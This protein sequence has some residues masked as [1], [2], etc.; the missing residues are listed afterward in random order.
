[1]LHA[2]LNY[3]WLKNADVTEIVSQL[4]STDALFSASE[5]RVKK[6]VYSR[7]LTALSLKR[8]VIIHI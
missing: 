3:N 4:G 1:M 5:T 2:Y 6:V 7:K 8:F